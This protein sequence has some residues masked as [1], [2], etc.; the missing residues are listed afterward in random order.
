MEVLYPA[1]SSKLNRQ[2]KSS[3]PENFYLLLEA[4]LGGELCATFLGTI[5]WMGL[6][7][8]DGDWFEVLFSTIPRK[9]TPPK[10]SNET[11]K[12][13]QNDCL[14]R[15]VSFSNLQYFQVVLPLVF[16]GLY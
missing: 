4:A 9:S 11:T 10:N 15:C 13:D 5:S 7:L 1:A 16:E 2:G 3:G 14:D 12:M 8:K 6:I